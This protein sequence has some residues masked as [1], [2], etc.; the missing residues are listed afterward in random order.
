VWN[1]PQLAESSD[2]IRRLGVLLNQAVRYMG[3]GGQD[4]D[5]L[6]AQVNLAMRDIKKLRPPN[7]EEGIPEITDAKTEAKKTGNTPQKNAAAVPPGNSSETTENASGKEG[8][9]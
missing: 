8:E 9:G 4:T 5:R 3:Q 2:Q 6:V 1:L 7:H